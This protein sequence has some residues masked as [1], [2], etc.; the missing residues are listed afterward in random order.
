MSIGQVRAARRKIAL[1]YRQPGRRTVAES[2]ALERRKA[3][4]EMAAKKKK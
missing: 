4:R 1:R 3:A 2:V